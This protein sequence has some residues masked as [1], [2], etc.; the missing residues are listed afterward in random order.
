MGRIKKFDVPALQPVAGASAPQ[1]LPAMEYATQHELYLTDKYNLVK[2]LLPSLEAG[3]SYGLFSFGQWELRHVIFHIARLIG[4]C[5]V[6]STTYGLGPRAARAIVQALDTGIFTSFMFLY[7]NK[8]REYKD[9][10]HNIC[11]SRFP[12]KLTSIHAKIT[13]LRNEKHAVLVAGSAN[14]SDSNN[15]IEYTTVITDPT[16][17]LRVWDIIAASIHA[18]ATQPAEILTEIQKLL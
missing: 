12:V 17:A 9:E 13:V 18:E 16:A 3:R 6:V 10:A 8:V 2:D 4:P 1:G 5:E 11:A 15:K 14:W 7:D